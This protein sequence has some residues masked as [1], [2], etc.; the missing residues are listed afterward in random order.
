VILL[1]IF[2][3]Y[4]SSVLFHDSESDGIVRMAHMMLNYKYKE[5]KTNGYQSFNRQPAIYIS[6]ASKFAQDEYKEQIAV[7]V[8]FNYNYNTYY[9]F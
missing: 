9:C 3:F 8:V 2:R 5:F 6:A 1:S 7:Q 4:D